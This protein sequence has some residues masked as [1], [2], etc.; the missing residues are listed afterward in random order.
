MTNGMSLSMLARRFVALG[1]FALFSSAL[2][3]VPSC[4]GAVCEAN[5]EGCPCE[6]AYLCGELPDCHGWL[7]DGRC[8]L[9]AS[10]PGNECLLTRQACFDSGACE[11][12]I[13]SAELQCVECVDDARCGP[14]HTCEAEGVCS[15]CDDGVKNGDETDVDY[16]GS[17][18]HGPGK[19]EVDA[20][21][22]DGY[23]WKGLCVSCHDG[24][25]NGDETGIDCGPS[26][27]HCKLCLGMD[28]SSGGDATCASNSCED[29]YCC[30]APCPRCY[31][32]TASGQ[33]QPLQI[34][35]DDLTNKDPNLVCTGAYTCGGANGCKLKTGQPCTT[36][37]ECAWNGCFQGK[38][39]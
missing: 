16:G 20:D 2:A 34:D 37:T 15:R 35:T 7:C 26:G 1:L 4:S 32:C 39:G 17:C 25:H 24:I 22:P 6:D 3:V 28:C 30:P 14:G 29:S 19:C 33:C 12:G 13:C 18:P 21:C 38:C 31:N 11:I 10:D 23:C 8:H 27:T 5:G 36:A 9:V